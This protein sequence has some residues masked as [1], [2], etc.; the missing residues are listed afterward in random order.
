MS[1]RSQN[2]VSRRTRK[3][4]IICIQAAVSAAALFLAQRLQKKR[5]GKDA[6]EV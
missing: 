4:P 2:T 1:K 6:E 3:Y 5:N